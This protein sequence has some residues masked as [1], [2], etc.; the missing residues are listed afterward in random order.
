MSSWTRA[1]KT[2]YLFLTEAQSA[3]SLD[4]GRILCGLCASVRDCVGLR[5]EP[6]LVDTPQ[7]M[8]DKEKR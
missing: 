1:K 6:A 5:A 7:A 3:Q 8:A 4:C 2:R